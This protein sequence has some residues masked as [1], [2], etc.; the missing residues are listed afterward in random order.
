MLKPLERCRF[1]VDDSG[2]L[3]FALS[4]VLVHIDSGEPVESN[5]GLYLTSLYAFLNRVQQRGIPMQSFAVR[6]G[7]EHAVSEDAKT[8][9]RYCSFLKWLLHGDGFD[10][11]AESYF[12]AIG[13]ELLRA[14]LFGFE[15]IRYE[16]ISDAL[17]SFVNGRDQISILTV[18]KD[19]PNSW[20]SVLAQ[21]PEEKMFRKT[22]GM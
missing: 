1:P 13:Y 12:I 3:S 22:L 17:P 11:D 20:L 8:K 19:F 21:F 14:D 15:Y 2:D 16:Q 9:L 4:N 7:L 6:Y 18:E 10:Q 5:V